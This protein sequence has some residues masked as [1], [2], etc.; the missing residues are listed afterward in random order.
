MFQ[1]ET[2]YR[3]VLLKVI[4]FSYNE[5]L[6][7]DELNHLNTKNSNITKVIAS[8][9]KALNG[10]QKKSSLIQTAIRD[11]HKK[12]SFWKRLFFYK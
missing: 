10:K 3:R 12:L 7:I 4:E 8:I 6:T 1:V 11:Y 9:E 5:K 2:I